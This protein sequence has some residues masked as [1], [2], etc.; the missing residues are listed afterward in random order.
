LIWFENVDIDT[1]FP[2]CYDLNDTQ[3]FEDFIEDYKISQAE[4]VLKDFQEKI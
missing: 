1:F 3:E 2:R 4:S